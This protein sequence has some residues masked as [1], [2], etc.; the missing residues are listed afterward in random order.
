MIL[1]E[2]KALLQYLHFSLKLFINCH[3]IITHYMTNNINFLRN[4]LQKQY[5][6]YCGNIFG[7]FE[8]FPGK[9]GM[10][11]TTETN[12]PSCLFISIPDQEIV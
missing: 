11:T 2:N 1:N 9:Y 4:A 10:H 8:R 5:Q 6:T 12:I 3:Q 7:L